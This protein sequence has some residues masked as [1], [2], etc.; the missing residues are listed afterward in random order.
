M[1]LS[2]KRAL[3]LADHEEILEL[4]HL[5]LNLL[6][7]G[8]THLLLILAHLGA[9]DVTIPHVKSNLHILSHLAR[10]ELPGAQAQCGH[11]DAFVEFQ[12][13]SHDCCRLH[14][15]TGTCAAVYES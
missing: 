2:W 15:Q 3:Q 6:L 1:L 7:E 12:M 14:T 9:V 8:H 10:R 5:R 13:A 4:H 11:L